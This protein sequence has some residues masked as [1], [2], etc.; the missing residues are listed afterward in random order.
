MSPHPDVFQPPEPE[1][2]PLRKMLM[3]G[4]AWHGKTAM[5]A[6]GVDVYNLFPP[7]DGS[8][9]LDAPVPIPETYVRERFSATDEDDT[10]H[11]REFFRIADAN[12]GDIM[13]GL[14]DVIMTAWCKG[15][16]DVG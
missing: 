13:A 4:G 5:I 2:K 6:D 9:L 15:E 1:A 10:V 12:P 8:R 11:P 3:I 14:I 16:I 7:M